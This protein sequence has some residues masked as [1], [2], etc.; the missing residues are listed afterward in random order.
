LGAAIQARSSSLRTKYITEILSLLVILALITLS[1]SSCS[2][3]K[4][5]LNLKSVGLEGSVDQ[6]SES[7]TEETIDEGETSI[8]DL[9]QMSEDRL[10][11]E[12]RYYSSLGLRE[13]ANRY[14][15]ELEGR[16]WILAD[17]VL[18]YFAGNLFEMGE[19]E[20][21]G[22]KYKQIFT[23][24]PDSIFITDSMLKSAI[25]LFEEEKFQESIAILNST[26]QMDLD[27]ANSAAA[28]LY[29]ARSY[30][31]I[32]DFDNASI[33]YVSLWVS[34]PTTNEA[35]QAE[36]WIRESA[37][38]GKAKVMV[39][40]GQ[41][42]ER[43]SVLISRG[44]YSRAL[45]E[46]ETLEEELKGTSPGD[47][48]REVRIK[49]A[50]VLYDLGNYERAIEEYKKNYDLFND[51]TIREES[52][53]Y[54]AKSEL[55]LGNRDEA[56][57]W[58]KEVWKQ[59][60]DGSLA[61]ASMYEAANVHLRVDEMDEAVSVYK[62]LINGYP[63]SDLV[64]DALWQ[65]GWINFRSGDYEEAIKFFSE[66]ESG[67][68]ESVLY[69]RS[70]YWAARA[71][72]KVGDTETAKYYLNKLV[73]RS[74]LSYYGILA[75]RRAKEFG[76][77][78]EQVT[79]QQLS[80]QSSS[81]VDEASLH[82]EKT[83][84]L[85]ELGFRTD[86]MKEFAKAKSAKTDE[87]YF[88]YDAM[89]IA[90]GEDIYDQV[91][92]ISKVHFKDV[93]AGAAEMPDTGFWKMAYPQG[94]INVVA[95]EAERNDIDPLILHALIKEESSYNPLAVSS[96]GAVGLMQIMPTTGEFIADKIS[97]NNY[98]ISFLNDYRINIKLGSWYLAYTLSQ[99]DGSIVRALAAYNGGPGNVSKWEKKFGDLE[100]DEFIESIP[101]WETKEYVKKVLRSYWEYKRIYG[102]GV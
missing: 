49:T 9:S 83:V 27:Y 43:V 53:Y 40:F 22:E 57:K 98:N 32:G 62:L 44:Y 21:A 79:N 35:E 87:R 102:T 23:K 95:N 86:G 5:A 20:S 28:R 47:I 61:A 76:I 45:E 42:T 78:L 14:F 31:G 99:F 41:R 72:H 11:L 54:I 6:T 74:P 73:A 34:N 82:I 37:S 92:Y 67:F 33:T 29:L 25:C 24:Y 46:L 91:I 4:T 100:D 50:K 101:F 80:L 97:L 77:E 8:P 48:Y 55:N 69:E 12:A 26:L 3:G 2:G 15:E 94:Y 16:D 17:H 93:V 70:A 59:F 19:Y 39:D 89:L 71:S 51:A 18:F 66:M 90:Y 1:S 68:P 96:A 88:W 7:G 75:E 58:F 30:E 81:K 63:E 10:Y 64:V 13:E 56:I 84:R 38:S 36:L 52:L 60:P 85:F 65:V